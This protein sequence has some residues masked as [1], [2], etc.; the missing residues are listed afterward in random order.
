MKSI[1]NHRYIS[2]SFSESINENFDGHLTVQFR[3]GDYAPKGRDPLA[4]YRLGK[5][6]KEIKPILRDLNIQDSVV[7]CNWGEWKDITFQ[8]IK[9]DDIEIIFNKCVELF[10]SYSD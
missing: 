6:V 9:K 3:W 4:H 8:Y 2:T 5:L 1:V 7:N 10:G